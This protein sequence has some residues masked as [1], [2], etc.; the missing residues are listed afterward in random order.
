MRSFA[1]VIFAPLRSGSNAV[2]KY[3]REVPNVSDSKPTR[4]SYV[5]SWTKTR[6][7]GLERWWRNHPYR[8]G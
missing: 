7:D 6:Y 3:E 5:S 8:S 2:L 1:L 4:A